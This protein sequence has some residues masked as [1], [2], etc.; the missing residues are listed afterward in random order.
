MEKEEYTWAF[1]LKILPLISTMLLVDGF[2][3]MKIWGWII[4]PIFGI[5]SIGYFESVALVIVKSYL[6]HNA[7]KGDFDGKFDKI[8]ASVFSKAILYLGLAW[9]FHLTL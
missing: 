1:A 2:V 5:K 9:I 8:F 3:F 7:V 6:L 4:T